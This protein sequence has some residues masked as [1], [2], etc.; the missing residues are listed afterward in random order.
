M[1]WQK[2]ASSQLTLLLPLNFV[3]RDVWIEKENAISVD[4][5]ERFRPRI[6]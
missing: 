3:M 5:D 4:V 1:E 2:G 6:P